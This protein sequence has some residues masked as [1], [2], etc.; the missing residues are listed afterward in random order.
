[1]ITLSIAESDSCE[2]RTWRLVRVKQ[3]QWYCDRN[4][5]WWWKTPFSI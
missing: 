5:L 4:S 1:M 2:I 3:Y